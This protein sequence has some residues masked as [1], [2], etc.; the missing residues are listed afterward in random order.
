MLIERVQ[1]ILFDNPNVRD[2]AMDAVAQSKI[3]QTIRAAERHYRFGFRI[4]Q[5]SETPAFSACQN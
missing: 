1:L 3:N 5:N 2:F 4:G